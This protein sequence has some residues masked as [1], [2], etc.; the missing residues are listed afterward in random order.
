M[1]ISSVEQHD[2][3][4]QAPQRL[5]QGKTPLVAGDLARER[6]LSRAYAVARGSLST[7]ARDCTGIAPRDTARLG[8]MAFANR[9]AKVPDVVAACNSASRVLALFIIAAVRARQ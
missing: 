1:V 5:H 6:T 2:G 4:R 9:S 8:R 3:R 7:A